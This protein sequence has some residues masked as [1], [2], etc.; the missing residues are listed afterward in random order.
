MSIVVM[1]NDVMLS[2]GIKATILSVI[3]QSFAIRNMVLS[4]ALLSAVMPR[5]IT[6]DI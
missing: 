5:V 6:T 4:V 1:L 2:V 3:M